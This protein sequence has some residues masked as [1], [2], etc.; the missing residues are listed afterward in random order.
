MDTLDDR[1]PVTLLTGFLGAG[2]T[3]LLNHLLRQPDVGKIAVIMN[4]F[5]DVGLDHDLI[6]EI[7]EDTVLMNAGC[8]C[9]SIR[10]DLAKTMVHLFA[11]MRRG[12][13]DFDRVLIE[14]TGIAD[15]GPILNTLVTDTFIAP[16]F[17]ADGVVAL[18]DAATGAQTLDTQ[19]EAVRQIAMADLI[20]L[21]KT[22]L[23]SAELRAQFEARLEAINNTARR[24]TADRGRVPT[25]ALFGLSAMQKGATPETMADW[26]GTDAH[27]RAG[28]D[29]HDHNHNHGHGHNHSHGH[30][31]DH[32][33]S[34]DHA[35]GIQ[36]A[37]IE[38][39]DPIP[40]RVFELWL[41]TLL[42]LKGQDIL[43]IKGIVHVEGEALPLAFHGVR[44][45]F[46]QPVPLTSWS[47]KDKTSRAVVIARDME[48]AELESSLNMLRMRPK[49][50]KEPAVSATAE[51]T[52]MPF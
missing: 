13:L 10:G 6:E 12:E 28:H 2:K 34:R 52:E 47:G 25:G 38:V 14:T 51:A 27:H 29:H 31:H 3:T 22:D 20:V 33:H 18:A 43:R 44:H 45:I 15:P 35:H 19:F 49:E 21:T 26:L 30:S 40:A 39:A 50:A 48:K 8:L 37:S 9:C 4:E 17:R 1:I 41:E 23:V 24:V 16:Y 32:G 7:T 42:T 11:R 5:G 36:S 46:E